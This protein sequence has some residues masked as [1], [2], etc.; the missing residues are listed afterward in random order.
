MYIIEF[1]S[2]KKKNSVMSFKKKKM[3]TETMILGEIS[4]SQREESITFALMWKLGGKTKGFHE[5]RWE[6]RRI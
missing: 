5:I 1:Y 2:T 6:I 3:E 4:Q